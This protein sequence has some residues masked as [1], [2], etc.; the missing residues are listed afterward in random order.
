MFFGSYRNLL[1]EDNYIRNPGFEQH[2]RDDTNLPHWKISEAE[3]YTVHPDS[4]VA[5]RGKVSLAIQGKHPKAAPLYIRQTRT[6]DADTVRRARYSAYVKNDLRAGKATLYALVKDERDRAIFYNNTEIY[7]TDRTDGWK[8]HQLDVLLDARAK[9]IT[10]GIK[11]E[12]Q[13]QIWFDVLEAVA[14]VEAQSPASAE[15]QNFINTFIDTVRAHTIRRDSIDWSQYQQALYERARG[16]IAVED[17][18]PVLRYGLGLLDDNHSSFKT[19]AQ[20]AQWRRRSV[21]EK[22]P[23]PMIDTLCIARTVGYVS[24]P[25]FGSGNQEDINRFADTLQ[26]R[27][28]QLD[29]QHDIKQWIV[30]LRQNLGGNMWPMLAGLGILNG[31][32]TLGDFRLVDERIVWRYEAG[33]ALENS[34]TAASTSNSSYQLRHPDPP[35]AVLVGPRT[36]SSGEAVAISF[37]GRACTK[38]FG[39][40]T[41]GISTANEGYLLPDSSLVNL[42]IAHMADRTGRVY[43][44]RIYPDTETDLPADSQTEDPAIDAAVR[45]LQ[46]PS[47]L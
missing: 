7:A 15:A 37:I 21:P 44:E 13:G 9:K 41:Y 38:S 19:P 28:I 5:Y 47:C 4:E 39:W 10:W 16:A 23:L 20:R 40:P 26:Q 36:A 31:E 11:V 42:T 14:T 34:D 18:Y 6:F 24:V 22:N 30:D 45:W 43:G 27:I 25:T 29:Q 1:T 46:Q 2:R 32:G 12:A 35:I 8:Q 33:S 17:T 3:D